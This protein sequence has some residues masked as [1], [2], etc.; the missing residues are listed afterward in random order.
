MVDVDDGHWS[1]ALPT[2]KVGKYFVRAL[3]DTGYETQK[4][5]VVYGGD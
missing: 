5:I 4:T 3:Y 2:P 1:Y